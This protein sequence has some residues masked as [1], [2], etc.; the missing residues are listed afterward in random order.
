M[1]ETIKKVAKKLDSVENCHRERAISQ[2]HNMAVAVGQRVHVNGGT[3]IGKASWGK[4]DWVEK[5]L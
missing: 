2:L 4:A 3:Y 1:P 5:V